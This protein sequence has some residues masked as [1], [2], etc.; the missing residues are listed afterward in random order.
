MKS[1]VFDSGP[2]ISITMNHILGTLKLIKN[3]YPGKFIIT[4]SVKNELVDRPLNIKNF[5]FEALQTLRCINQGVIEVAH[6]DKIHKLGLRLETLANNIFKAR[7]SWIRIVH[8]AEMETVAAALLYNSEAIVIDERTTRLM[9][10]KPQ[11]LHKILEHKLH[12][13]IFINHKNL[14]EFLKLAK[15]IKVIRSIE[16]ILIAYEKG[17][18][19]KY[20]PDMPNPKKLLLDAMLWGI[21]LDGCSV[22]R[23]EIEKAVNLELKER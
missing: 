15:G 6:D 20:I 7:G 1:I 3:Y 2:I 13:K 18:F 5:M 10:E 11:E 9:I 19:D 16:L 8:I 22:S 17:L 14:N 21:K 4:E 12:T 23:K